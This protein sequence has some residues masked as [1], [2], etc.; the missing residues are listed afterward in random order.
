[1]VKS[2]IIYNPKFVA[3]IKKSEKNFKEGKYI[4]IKVENLWK[5]Q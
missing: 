3:K 1:M 2:K 5:E 4:S